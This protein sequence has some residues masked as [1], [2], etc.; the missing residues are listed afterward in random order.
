MPCLR[1]AGVK[2]SS[3]AEKNARKGRKAGYRLWALIFKSV[4]FFDAKNFINMKSFH[5]QP[6]VIYFLECPLD[7]EWVA[8]KFI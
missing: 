3:S 1:A 5:A 2:F 6:I 4:T 8:E 7:F